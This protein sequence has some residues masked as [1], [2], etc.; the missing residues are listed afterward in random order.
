MRSLM[1]L[2]YIL[3][4]FMAKTRGVKFLHCS[5]LL[6]CSC[7]HS[8]CGEPVVVE[9]EINVEYNQNESDLLLSFDASPAQSV[10]GLI[11]NADSVSID[12]SVSDADSARMTETELDDEYTPLDRDA[13]QKQK[14]EIRRTI[15][16][17]YTGITA[18]YENNIEIRIPLPRVAMNFD[19][20]PE[21]RTENVFVDGECY[22]G[23]AP[24]SSSLPPSEFCDCMIRFV[25]GLRFNLSNHSTTIRVRYP[26]HFNVVYS[27]LMPR[28]LRGTTT[29]LFPI[30]SS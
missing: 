11:Y 26:F 9:D 25:L 28:S 27:A 19:I 4:F 21:G 29:A 17:K 23:P 16:R 15:R 18:C 30:T 1:L 20:T 7:C 6:L 8:R 24:E 14:N 2:R 13:Q 3:C 10:D 5:L 12:G 22:K